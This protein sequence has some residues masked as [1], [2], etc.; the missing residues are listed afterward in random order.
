MIEPFAVRFNLN[1]EFDRPSKI[2]RYESILFPIDVLYMPET[3]DCVEIS[4][5]SIVYVGLASS[6]KNNHTHIHTV[7]H[8]VR[9][10]VA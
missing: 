10:F 8:I 1:S 3:I 6:S 7:I 9:I 4:Y 2:D 5:Q